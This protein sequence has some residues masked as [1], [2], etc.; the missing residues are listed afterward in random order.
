LQIRPIL[1]CVP[2]CYFSIRTS[3]K[4][5]LSHP[6]ETPSRDTPMI[7]LDV[8]LSSYSA[9]S[10]VRFQPAIHLLKSIRYRVV[11]W[12][13]R[14]RPA[15]LSALVN[16]EAKQKL[17]ISIAFEDAELIDWQARLVK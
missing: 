1:G 4:T 9:S 17:L 5:H 11:D 3:T 12:R 6:L 13:Y 8:D 10:W 2:L 16:G 14:R 7:V 15:R